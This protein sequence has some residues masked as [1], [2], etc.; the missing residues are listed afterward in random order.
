MIKWIKVKKDGQPKNYIDNNCYLIMYM[1]DYEFACF[2]S[3]EWKVF[4]GN[5]L[6]NA[7]E[8]IEYYARL[9]RPIK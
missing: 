6:C 1:G 2:N 8:P 9:N 5:Q 4:E 7:Q 3:G